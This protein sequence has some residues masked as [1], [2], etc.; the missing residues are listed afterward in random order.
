MLCP[1]PLPAP[2]PGVLLLAWGQCS[3]P[4]PQPRS[5]AGRGDSRPCLPRS[6]AV[7]GAGE[8]AVPAGFPGGGGPGSG[9][10]AGGRDALLPGPPGGPGLGAPAGAAGHRPGAA[11]GPGGSGP[12]WERGAV[13]RPCC[14]GPLSS[15]PAHSATPPGPSAIPSHFIHRSPQTLCYPLPVHSQSPLNPFTVSSQ[16]I[17]NPLPAPLSPLQPLRQPRP[18]PLPSPPSPSAPSPAPAGPEDGAL[19]PSPAGAARGARPALRS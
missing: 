17:Q 9:R 1:F 6:S 15:L 8:A 11:A 3:E 13:P 18:V 2:V 14:P 4:L 5:P 10:A 12:R 16:S 19:T 7:G